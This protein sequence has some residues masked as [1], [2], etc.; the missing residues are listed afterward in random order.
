MHEPSRNSRG[1]DL[2]RPMHIRR[3]AAVSIVTGASCCSSAEDLN[4]KRMLAVEAPRLPLEGCCAPHQ[5]RCRFQKYVD[6]RSDD[7]SRRLRDRSERSIWYA[8]AQ[9]R[10]S[11]GR[12]A[13][14][15]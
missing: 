5:C 1:V 9:R 6:R 7:E 8:G 3:Y 12:R 11:H 14:D 13:G 4:G 2:N 15:Y 10:K